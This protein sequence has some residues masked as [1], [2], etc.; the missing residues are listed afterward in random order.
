MPRDWQRYLSNA[1]TDAGRTIVEQGK[2][3][4]EARQ[5]LPEK[6]YL[7]LLSK[8]ESTEARRPCR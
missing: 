2:R 1:H 7:E 4:H 8:P 5:N 6:R 3:L